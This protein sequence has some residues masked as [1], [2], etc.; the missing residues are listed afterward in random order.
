MQ[1]SAPIGTLGVEPHS[2]IDHALLEAQAAQGLVIL[3]I[4]LPVQHLPSVPRAEKALVQMEQPCGSR[5]LVCRNPAYELSRGT[6]Q[7]GGRGF[8][9][10][11]ACRIGCEHGAARTPGATPLYYKAGMQQAPIGARG[12][13]AAQPLQSRAQAG[14][15]R[16]P[17]M[18]SLDVLLGITLVPC[19][20]AQRISTCG[21]RRKAGGRE[22]GGDPDWPHEKQPWRAAHGDDSCNAMAGWPGW[23]GFD[24]GKVSG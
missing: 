22:E 14:T 8:E 11:S 1:R 23:L 19:C 5:F 24:E 4:Q 17:R 3:L 2:T 12:C 10:G 15:C 20:S 6:F 7:E 13:W 18:R 21:S 16:L 9:R